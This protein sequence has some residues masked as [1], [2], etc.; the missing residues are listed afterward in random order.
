MSDIK[1]YVAEMLGSMVL[2]IVGV[3][4]LLGFGVNG[5]VGVAFAFGLTVVAL[6]YTIGPISGCHINPAVTIGVMAI[7]GMKLKDGVMYVI[8]QLIG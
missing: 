8:F 6:I 5:L 3:G 4:A 7:K 2:V 1:K